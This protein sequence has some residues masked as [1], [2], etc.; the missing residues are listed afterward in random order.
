MDSPVALYGL[1]VLGSL[2]RLL[3]ERDPHPAVYETLG[4][5]IDDAP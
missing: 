1:S 3:P 2:F 5:V 4:V